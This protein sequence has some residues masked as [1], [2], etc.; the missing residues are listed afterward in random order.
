MLPVRAYVRYNSRLGYRRFFLIFKEVSFQVYQYIINTEILFLTE[1]KM[2]P[3]EA[4]QNMTLKDFIAY[5]KG[6]ELRIKEKND[7]YSNSK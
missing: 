4:F 2:D 6:M 5:I 3:F 7:K 1:F